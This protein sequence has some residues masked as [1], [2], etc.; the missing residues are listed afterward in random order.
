MLMRF[1]RGCQQVSEEEE[2]HREYVGHMAPDKARVDDGGLTLDLAALGL[3][4]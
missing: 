4:R 3:Q 2:V 1:Q